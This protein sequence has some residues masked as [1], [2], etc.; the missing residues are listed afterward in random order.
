MTNAP[1]SA[2]AADPRIPTTLYAGYE[3]GGLVKSTDGGAGWR[4]AEVGLTRN[5]VYTRPILLALTIDPTAPDTVIA[6]TDTGIFMSTDGGD[7]WRDLNAGFAASTLVRDPTDPRILYAIVNLGTGDTLRRSTDG[8]ISWAVVPTGFVAETIAVDPTTSTTLYAGVGAYLSTPGTVFKSTDGG[9]GWSKLTLGFPGAG[10]IYRITI[11][12]RTP[13]TVYAGTD[14][15]VFKSTDGGASWNHEFASP[16]SVY[17]LVID[18]ATSTTLY[19]GTSGSNGRGV[20]RSTDGGTTWSDFNHGLRIS[21]TSVLVTAPH[22]PDTLYAGGDGGSIFVIQPVAVCAG[23]CDGAGGVTV[24]DI[25]TMV[26]VALG[27]ADVT[28]CVAGDSN[29]DGAITVD[30][31][32]AAVNNALNVTCIARIP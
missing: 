22:T 18:R 14:V 26:N 19:A 21:F 12:P 27:D 23:D 7:A 20:L 10:T 9:G 6:S 4:S 28:S 13:S 15:G 1:I 11:D 17:A 16:A 24:D 29:E 25:V 5:A 3:C 2:L 8:G 30:E 31:V 32:L